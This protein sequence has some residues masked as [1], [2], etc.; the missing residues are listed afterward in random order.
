MDVVLFADVDDNVSV[1]LLKKNEIKNSDQNFHFIYF[2]MHREW[3]G[4]KQQQ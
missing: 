3:E 2:F 1:E 4:E